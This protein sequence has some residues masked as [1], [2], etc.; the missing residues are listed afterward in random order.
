MRSG[1]REECDEGRGEI[2]CYAKKLDSTIDSLL[3]VQSDNERG[4]IDDLLADG[5]VSLADEDTG[6]VDGLG[7]TA[8][9]VSES[10]TT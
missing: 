2:G 4:N 5:D 9:N 3:R 1:G 6:V 10:H 7:E 8:S